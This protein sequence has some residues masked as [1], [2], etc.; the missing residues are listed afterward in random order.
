MRR[1]VRVPHGGSS[2]WS[3]TTPRGRLRT[4]VPADRFQ[5]LARGIRW[6]SMHRPERDGADPLARIG[7]AA[8]R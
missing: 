5:L 1:D 2:G 3:G 8:R 4:G 6:V 7:P